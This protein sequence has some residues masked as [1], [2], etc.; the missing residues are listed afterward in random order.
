MTKRVLVVE[1]MRTIGRSCAILSTRR[2]R[3]RRSGRWCGGLAMAVS[4]K[5]DSFSWKS[6]ALVMEGY[7]ATRRSG[8][9]PGRPWTSR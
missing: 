8:R 9:K 1:D 2:L 3:R 7:E 5:T 4:D 6:Q